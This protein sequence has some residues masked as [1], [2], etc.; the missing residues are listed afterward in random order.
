VIRH[1]CTF[2]IAI[3]INKMA[4]FGAYEVETILLKQFDDLLWR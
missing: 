4:S 1:N 3:P 2:A